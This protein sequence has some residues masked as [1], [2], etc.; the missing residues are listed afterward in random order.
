MAE[1]HESE[2]HAGPSLQVYLIIAVALGVFTV[3]SFVVNY[4]VREHHLTT[5]VGFVLILGVAVCKAVLVGMFFMHLK[6]DWFKLYFLIV[7]VFIMAAMMMMVL[8][9]DS[10]LAWH[11]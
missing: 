11:K 1:T 9:P 2:S 8:L 6:Y 4:L 7:P 5:Q 3:S 10:V